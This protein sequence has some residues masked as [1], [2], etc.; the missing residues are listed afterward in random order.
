MAGGSRPGPKEVAELGERGPSE[1]EG[2]RT[3]EEQM[4]VGSSKRRGCEN[5]RRLSERWGRPIRARG[6]ADLEAPRLGLVALSRG[7]DT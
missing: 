4:P 6:V 1:S 5:R 7:G 3:R 2:L